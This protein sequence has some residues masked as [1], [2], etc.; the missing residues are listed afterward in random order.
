MEWLIHLAIHAAVPY[1]S[2]YWSI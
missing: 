2:N 1:R